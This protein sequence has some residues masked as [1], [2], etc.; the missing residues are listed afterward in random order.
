MK[1]LGR[2]QTVFPE[3]RMAA[4]PRSASSAPFGDNKHVTGTDHQSDAENQLKLAGCEKEFL[5]QFY[6]RFQLLRASFFATHPATTSAMG[7]YCGMNQV[8][9]V[10]YLRISDSNEKL[11][12]IEHFF[13][14][15]SPNKVSFEPR[16]YAQISDAMTFS[17]RYSRR[18]FAGLTSTIAAM[19]ASEHS[20]S[21]HQWCLATSR[22]GQCKLWVRRD[23]VTD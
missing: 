4:R 16:S 12:G 21:L 22:Q 14:L 23:H 5:L 6:R 7:Q 17:Y 13:L 10:F 11:S 9:L 3:R 19:A 15:L 2:F 1:R 8:R 20:S 18:E